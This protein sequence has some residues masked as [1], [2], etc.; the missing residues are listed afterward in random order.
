MNP[1]VINMLRIC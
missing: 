1:L